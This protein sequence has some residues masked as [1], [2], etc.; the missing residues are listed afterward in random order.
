MSSTAR[1]SET[2]LR[3]L[4]FSCCLLVV[5]LTSL[6]CSTWSETT[7]PRVSVGIEYDL[8][9]GVSPRVELGY[10]YLRFNWVTGWGGGGG[11]SWSVLN[12]RL[13]FYAEGR[14]YT[15]LA[16][17]GMVMRLGGVLGVGKY[18]L[19]PGL[20]FGAGIP[21]D[22]PPKACTVGIEGDQ[23]PIEE[24]CAG[25]WR[26]E[27]I[28]HPDWQGELEF[29]GMWLPRIRPN[30]FEGIPDPFRSEWYSPEDELVFYLGFAANIDESVLTD[31]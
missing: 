12:E 15:F 19:R 28:V 5:L 21:L 25:Q 4:P 29:V 8:K 22:W 24:A 31:N 13:D 18:G 30:A 11:L 9:D 17:P 6:G 7:G 23:P 27:D 20:R 26:V 14:F 2:L 3:Q 1:W 10:Q 16:S